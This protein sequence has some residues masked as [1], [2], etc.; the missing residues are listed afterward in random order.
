M[1]VG[2]RERVRVSVRV[3][4]RV[5]VPRPQIGLQFL[6]F[7]NFPIDNLSHGNEINTHIINENHGCL[8]R[9]VGQVPIVKDVVAYADEVWKILEFSVFVLKLPN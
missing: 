1:S 4:I 3:I 2:V 5:R 9:L 6:Y 8:V 7:K